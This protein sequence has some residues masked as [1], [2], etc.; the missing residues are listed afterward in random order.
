M[1]AIVHTINI[2]N[3]FQIFSNGNRSTIVNAVVCGLSTPAVSVSHIEIAPR[4]LI[5]SQMYLVLYKY[6]KKKKKGKERAESV[7]LVSLLNI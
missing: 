5:Q 6:G 4:S 1:H 2:A 3:F 7:K